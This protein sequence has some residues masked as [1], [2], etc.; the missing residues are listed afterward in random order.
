MEPGTTDALIAAERGSGDNMAAILENFGINLD[1][2]GSDSNYVHVK[3]E[4]G[5]LNLGLRS[6]SAGVFN[7]R[8][9]VSERC[10]GSP[11]SSDLP[12]EPLVHRADQMLVGGYVSAARVHAAASA[13]PELRRDVID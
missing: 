1:E 8:F 6:G 4:R 9:A 10:H 13:V 5:G 3:M 11:M 12:V 2:I 7:S